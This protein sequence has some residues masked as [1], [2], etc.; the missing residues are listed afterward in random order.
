MP[1]SA[2]LGWSEVTKQ[3]A[4]VMGLTWAAS[5]ITKVPPPSLCCLRFRRL[6]ATQ[7]RAAWQES[8]MPRILYGSSLHST[9]LCALA[10]IRLCST[11]HLCVQVPRAALALFLAPTADG[12]LIYVQARCRLRTRRNALVFLVAACFL[13]AAIVFGGCMALWL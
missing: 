10:T 9:I 12:I 4:T 3:F 11:R 6:Q 13:L 2:G 5:Q 7:S 1:F 8:V